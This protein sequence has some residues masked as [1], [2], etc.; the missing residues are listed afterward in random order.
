MLDMRAVHEVML[1]AQVASR[2]WV[3]RTMDLVAWK[4]EL[5][6]WNG[7]RLAIWDPCTWDQWRR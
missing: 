2:V 3:M 4:K 1:A 5:D 6:V 7:E